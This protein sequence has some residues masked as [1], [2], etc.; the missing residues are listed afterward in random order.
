MKTKKKK[1]RLYNCPVKGCNQLRP[2]TIHHI[3]PDRIFGKTPFTVPMCQECHSRL[4]KMIPYGRELT[5]GEYF[6]IAY[7]FV[8]GKKNMFELRKTLFLKG[9][10]NMDKVNGITILPVDIG[11]LT[12]VICHTKD[13]CLNVVPQIEAIEKLRKG[14]SE[15]FVIVLIDRSIKLATST[16]IWLN[17]HNVPFNAI[18]FKKIPAKMYKSEV[19][20]ID[21]DGTMTKEVCWTPKQCIEATPRMEVIE[22]MREE[23]S[24][25]LVIP[26]TA[27]RIELATPTLIWLDMHKIPFHAISFNKMPADEY[28]D[29]KCDHFGRWLRGKGGV[30]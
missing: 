22:R 29:D 23:F 6:D 17:K 30:K 20:A 11:T 2:F 8:K 12:K 5:P 10:W 27:R 26:L 25:R 9:G 19:L 21:I 4:E 16:W 3:L 15:H 13:E 14:F 24:S 28:V 7:S 1:K 18:S